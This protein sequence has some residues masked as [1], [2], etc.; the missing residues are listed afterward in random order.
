MSETQGIGIIE[1]SEEEIVKIDPTSELLE[2]IKVLKEEK[3]FLQNLIDSTA[4][5]NRSLKEELEESRNVS[6]QLNDWL[7][8]GSPDDKALN[9]KRKDSLPTEWIVVETNIDGPGGKWGINGDDLLLVGE[10]PKDLIG[11]I[12]IDKLKNI[13]INYEKQK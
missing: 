1:L 11:W 10:G 12:P 8:N 4:Q 3:L 7:T 13:L 2:Q 6:R 5:E 9:I